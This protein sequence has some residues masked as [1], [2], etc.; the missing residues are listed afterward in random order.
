MSVNALDIRVKNNL[1]EIAERNR[2]DNAHFLHGAG[3]GESGYLS[4]PP[5]LLRFCPPSS[6]NTSMAMAAAARALAE[7]Y[8]LPT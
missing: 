2:G 7:P 3:P 5:P 6:A 1:A 4:V 8:R